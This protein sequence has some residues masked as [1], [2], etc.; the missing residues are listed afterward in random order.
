MA[1]S[2][3]KDIGAAVAAEIEAVENAGRVHLYQRTAADM[4]KYIGLFRWEAPD[5]GDQIRGWIVTRERVSEALGG[6][7]ASAPG[8]LIP[9]GVNR[10]AHTFLLAGIMGL[11]DGAASELVFQDLIEAVCDRFRSNDALRLRSKVPTLERLQPPQVDVIEP[12]A[13]GGVL[14]HYAEIRLQAFERITRA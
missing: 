6:F 3:Y 14:C 2:F 1:S 8:G 4:A 9:A 11:K 13:F 7:G 10:R 5:G 12:R